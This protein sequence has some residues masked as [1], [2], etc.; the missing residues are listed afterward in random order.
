MRATGQ[1]AGRAASRLISGTH[2]I[3]SGKGSCNCG[4]SLALQRRQLEAAK[5]ITAAI[6]ELGELTPTANGFA[7]RAM[8]AARKALSALENGEE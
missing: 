1:A 4:Q 2:R 8:T 7:G 5:H 6:H 3:E